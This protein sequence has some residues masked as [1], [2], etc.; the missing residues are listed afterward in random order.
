M[1]INHEPVEPATTD[2]AAVKGVAVAAVKADAAVPQ[3]KT[4]S[5]EEQVIDIVAPVSAGLPSE[6]NETKAASVEIEATAVRLGRS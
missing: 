1:L 3:V 6:A 5:A 2:G 4:E